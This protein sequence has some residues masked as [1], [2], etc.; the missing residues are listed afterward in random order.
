MDVDEWVSS[1]VG[2][3]QR[4]CEKFLSIPR[5]CTDSKQTERKIKRATILPSFAWKI[6]IKGV[7]M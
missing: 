4:E 3:C 1:L 2:W 6:A 7:Y 5:V